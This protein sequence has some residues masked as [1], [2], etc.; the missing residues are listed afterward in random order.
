MHFSC[1][2]PREQGVGSTETL[3]SGRSCVAPVVGTRAESHLFIIKMLGSDEMQSAPCIQSCGLKNTIQHCLNMHL[4]QGLV[5][6]AGPL[7]MATFPWVK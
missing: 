7:G 4:N 3:C 5:P 6:A 1:R 2:P